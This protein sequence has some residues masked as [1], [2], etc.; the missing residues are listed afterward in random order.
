[1][2]ERAAPTLAGKVPDSRLFV[3]SILQLKPAANIKQMA[4]YRL[5]CNQD[6]QRRIRKPTLQ[7][8]NIQCR[9]TSWWKSGRP[10]YLNNV[11]MKNSS[12]GIGPLMRLSPAT[13]VSS[14]FS[15]ATLR[16]MVPLI[17]LRSNCST[18]KLLS[19]YKAPG[20]GPCKCRSFDQCLS[21][22]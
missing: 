17:A 16:E 8:Q 3:R 2:R 20:M 13:N 11:R 5:Y 19:E 10:P 9:C 12:A 6:G 15:S 7:W 14:L 1:M 21:T 22:D 4:T 18:C